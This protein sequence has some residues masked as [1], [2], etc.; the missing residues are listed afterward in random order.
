MT[1]VGV[2]VIAGELEGVIFT[3]L[4][5]L[6]ICR[7]GYTRTCVFQVFRI[8]DREGGDSRRKLIDDQ[9]ILCS[10]SVMQ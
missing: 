8:G 2:V 9:I 1:E 10:Q 6:T 5:P 7:E 4:I 3:I